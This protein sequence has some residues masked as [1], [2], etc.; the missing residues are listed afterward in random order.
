M[1][2][3]RIL[4]RVKNFQALRQKSTDHAAEHIAASS[5]SHSGVAG[6]IDI[7]FRTAISYNAAMAFKDNYSIIIFS[8]LFSNQFPVFIYKIK[9]YPKKPG[10]LFGVRS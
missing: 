9:I 8:V 3:S 7:K 2:I 4:C 6:I 5:S 10:H 1:N